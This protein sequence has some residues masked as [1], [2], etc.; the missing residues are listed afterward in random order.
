MRPS[1]FIFSLPRSGSSWL[2]VFLSGSDSF[3]YHE[4]TAD[5][6]PI[7]WREAAIQRPEAIVGAIDTGAMYYADKIWDSIPKAKFF[8]LC[9]DTFEIDKSCRWHGLEF[10]AFKE[11]EKLD[12]LKHE[13]ILYSKFGDIGYMEEVWDRVIGTKFDSERAKI[14]MEMR[15]ERDITKFFTA[16]PNA[17]EH[18]TELLH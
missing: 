5:L 4:P 7:E 2:S 12:V 3:C 8:S 1:F 11:R 10:D 18:A 13:R 15:I 9:R 16:R 6:S 14:I 17:I